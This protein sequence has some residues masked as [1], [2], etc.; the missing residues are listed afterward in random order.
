MGVSPLRRFIYFQQSSLRDKLQ[1]FL[2]TSGK[3]QRRG[4]L[5]RR[6]LKI[7]YPTLPQFS[8]RNYLLKIIISPFPVPN[9][10]FFIATIFFAVRP[11]PL[12]LAYHTWPL[13]KRL[14]RTIQPLLLLQPRILQPAQLPLHQ[15]NRPLPP[16][17]SSSV[18]LRLLKLQNY[19]FFHSH[20]HHYR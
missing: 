3:I 10:L 7:F 20:R 18:H 4:P 19:K 11:Q 9:T 17:H 12:Q 13:K 15:L 2:A 5:P 14:S 16:I 1:R 6:L 8:Q